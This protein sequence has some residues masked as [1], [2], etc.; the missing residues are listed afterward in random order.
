MIPASFFVLPFL[1]ALLSEATRAEMLAVARRCLGLACKTWRFYQTCQ[2]PECTA[3]DLGMPLALI[4]SGGTAHAGASQTTGHVRGRGVSV[5]VMGAPGSVSERRKRFRFTQIFSHLLAEQLRPRSLARSL[6]P[7][8]PLSSLLPLPLPCLTQLIET[9]NGKI[10]L[11]PI[12]PAFLFFFEQ[13]I[14]CV[15]AVLCCFLKAVSGQLGLE[16]AHFGGW[17]GSTY[18][19]S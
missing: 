4:S 18:C 1:S 15:D 8:L 2:Y 19:F 11:C 17:G 14:G 6:P 10:R 5:F 7:S 16:A 9:L 12:L 13:L 3:F